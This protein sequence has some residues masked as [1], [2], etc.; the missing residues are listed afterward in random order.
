MENLLTFLDVETPNLKNDSICSIALVQT[1]LNGNEI[2]KHY[3]LV[4]PEDRFD[5][6][7]MSI[8][9][10]TPFMVKTEP[11]FIELWNDTLEDYFYNSVLIA[12][13]ATFDLNVLYKACQNYGIDFGDH[14]YICT[15][16]ISKK[17]LKNLE[18]Y[19]L[20]TICQALNIDFSNHHNACNDALGCEQIYYAL[21]KISKEDLINYKELYTGP[22]SRKYSKEPNQRAFSESTTQFQTLINLS[23]QI[24]KDGRVSFEEA[25]LLLTFLDASGIPENDLVI[26]R[27]KDNLQE[28]LTDGDISA[29]ESEALISDLNRIIDPSATADSESK[30]EFTNRSFCLTGSFEHGSKDNINQYIIDK[31]GVILKSV[32]KKCDYVVVGG[33]GSEAYAFGKYGSKVKKALEMQENGSSIKIIQECDLFK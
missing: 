8:H 4:N 23:E 29:H 16:Q 10:I 15:H 1:D 25:M 13:Q 33:C 28:C 26:S 24:I 2:R 6:K 30:I 7:P 19:K 27:L 22:A 31:G 14:D 20:P 9:G 32:T 18:N 5:D 12:H 11:S 17:L 21:S 3:Q